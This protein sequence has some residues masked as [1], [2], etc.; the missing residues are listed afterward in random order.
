MS[1]GVCLPAPPGP[2]DPVLASALKKTCS[3]VTAWVPAAG[4]I[5]GYCTTTYYTADPPAH[6]KYTALKQSEHHTYGEGLGDALLNTRIA[7]LGW[8]PADRD[9]TSAA[10]DQLIQLTA[11]SCTFTSNTVSRA[12]ICKHHTINGHPVFIKIATT[13]RVSYEV[14]VYRFVDK[15]VKPF[16]RNVVQLVQSCWDL[17]PA[18]KVTLQQ[19]L[20]GVRLDSI[21]AIITQQVDPGPD[22]TTETL[23]A[24]LTSRHVSAVDRAKAVFQVLFTLYIMNRVGM[25]HNDAHMNNVLMDT[26]KATEPNAFYSYRDTESDGRLRG[27]YVASQRIPRIYDYDFSTVRSLGRNYLSSTYGR[28]NDVSRYRDLINVIYGYS[29]YVEERSGPISNILVGIRHGFKT[30]WPDNRWTPEKWL[31]FLCE[32]SDNQF[33][34]WLNMTPSRLIME[35][36]KLTKIREPDTFG[37]DVKRYLNPSDA[38]LGV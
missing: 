28:C 29:E 37:A 34:A 15:R 2:N 18:V 21:R 25:T 30:R 13:L 5:A 22:G 33:N 11:G 23:Y 9:A 19:Q 6:F 3:P 7:E 24:Y 20:N 1:R 14:E 32:S 27:V 35:F 4:D 10:C 12:L 38:E 31:I 16:T 26:R 36:A 8:A 17:P